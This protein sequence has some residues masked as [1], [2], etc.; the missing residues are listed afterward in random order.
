M[1]KCKVYI[2]IAKCKAWDHSVAEV[3]GLPKLI[4]SAHVRFPFEKKKFWFWSLV[5]DAQKLY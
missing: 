5:S 2:K 1:P 4:E 3:V